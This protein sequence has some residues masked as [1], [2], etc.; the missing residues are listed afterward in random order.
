MSSQGLK[1]NPSARLTEMCPR[2]PGQSTRGSVG[3]FCR[4]GFTVIEMIGAVTIA[5][6]LAGA[7]VWSVGGTADRMARRTA[8]TGLAWLDRNARALNTRAV[9]VI[10][11]TERRAWVESAGG[12]FDGT[13]QPLGQLGSPWAVEWGPGRGIS[14]VQ[15]VEGTLQSGTVRLPFAAN[16]WSP[17]Y[18]LR[19]EIE[20]EDRAVFE[21]VAGVTGQRTPGLTPQEAEEVL[22]ALSRPD[23]D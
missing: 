19:W 13:L 8:Q 12:R 15:T 22:R 7:V 3:G 14:A 5:A 16:G 6:L 21:V 2:K 4:A 10:D 11:L 23:L 17:T 20:R 18:V 9:L 1:P